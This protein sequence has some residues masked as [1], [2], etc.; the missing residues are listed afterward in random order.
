LKKDILICVYAMEIG[1]IER[2]LINM[3]E[4]FDYEA[5]NV[6]LFI[7]HHSGE[8]MDFIPKEVTILPEK[9]CYTVFRKSL[10]QSIKEGHYFSSMIRVISKCRASI[11]AKREKF[12]EGSGYVQ[13]Q[14]DMKYSLY[15]MPKLPKKYDTAISYAWPHD[16]VIRK[17]DAD[18]K[19]AWIHTDYSKLEVEPK[20]DFHIWKQYDYIVAV[21]EDCGASFFKQ[22]PT[23]KSNI[24]IIENIT[25][26]DFIKRLSSEQIENAMLNDSRFKIITVARLSYAKGID[27][28]VKALKILKDK[29]FDN[30]AW[31]VVGY[32]GEEN[33]IKDLI[34][35][36]RL[37]NDFILL[38]KKT[39]PYPY[40]KAADLYVQ[41][42]RYE[43]K[44]VTVGEAQILEKPILITNYSTASSQLIHDF[45][46]M[47]CVNSENDIANAIKRLYLDSSLRKKLSTNCSN[48]NYS[49]GENLKKLYEIVQEK[50]L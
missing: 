23:L 9:S 20:L 27:Q 38:G 29:G 40:I 48:T 32:G 45:D 15:V 43:G 18:K 34:T 19:I 39:N 24:H 17:V 46:G 44:A 1:G 6:D 11:I 33:T 4:S 13:M 3:L 14:L 12:K 7:L 26:P 47:I 2:S 50:Y 22:Y 8:F 30:I 5:Y 41:P 31:Y 16:L 10:K 28:A 49:N 25:A 42:S 21:S 36:N 35:K 37:E